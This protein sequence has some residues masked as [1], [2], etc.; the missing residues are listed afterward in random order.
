MFGITLLQNQSVTPRLPRQPTHRLVAG[1]WVDLTDL[2]PRIGLPKTTMPLPRQG[3]PRES[4]MS[5]A[6]YS[7]SVIK[8]HRSTRGTLSTVVLNYFLRLLF[9][10]FYFFNFKFPT[11]QCRDLPKLAAEFKVAEPTIRWLLS[12]Y[13]LPY[14]VPDG[15]T[16][17][18]RKSRPD[19][20]T[21]R[22]WCVRPF[23]T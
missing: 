2:F 19:A 5:F 20:D 9:L 1:Q 12:Q 8:R 17:R 23:F 14:L 16:I 10:Y 18:A 3:Y 7:C 21:E 15:E 4:W 11:F 13:T 22:V 6:C